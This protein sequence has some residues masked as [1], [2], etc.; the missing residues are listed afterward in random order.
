MCHDIV[1]Y[2][3]DFEMFCKVNNIITLCMPPHS[4]HFLQPLDVE[5]FGPLKQSYGGQ[6]RVCRD[7]VALKISPERVSNTLYKR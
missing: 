7:S 2:S 3:T 6:S 4:S 5:R 1:L